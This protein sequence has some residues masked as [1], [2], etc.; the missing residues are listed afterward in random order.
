MSDVISY[1][2]DS[3]VFSKFNMWP[4]LECKHTW[5]HSSI[6]IRIQYVCMCDVYVMPMCDVYASMCICVCLLACVCLWVC[7]CMCVCVCVFLCAC[8]YVYIHSCICIQE[9][10]HFGLHGAVMYCNV[11]L[12]DG[13]CY[14]CN[15]QCG[16]LTNSLYVPG[17]S[18][19]SYNWK[20]CAGGPFSSERSYCLMWPQNCNVVYCVP[21]PSARVC[22]CTCAHVRVCIHVCVCVCAH[23]C[24]LVLLCSNIVDEIENFPSKVITFLHVTWNN[25]CNNIYQ[26]YHKLSCLHCTHM[27][28]VPPHGRRVFHSLQKI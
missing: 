24:G 17:C 6:R 18:G 21:V 16:Q 5:P 1:H 14:F 7:V 4:L 28:Q 12:Q 27:Q 9:C 8:V 15:N 13:D 23:E 11:T 19:L 22:M 25:Y 3:K 2:C 26:L 10:T 20:S